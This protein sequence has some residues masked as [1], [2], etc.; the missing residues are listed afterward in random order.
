LIHAL[1]DR[2]RGIG[3]F[4]NKPAPGV[5]DVFLNTVRKDKTPVVI[6]LVSGIK[7]IG[8]I[9]SFDKYSVLLENNTENNILEQLIYKHSISTVVSCRPGSGAKPATLHIANALDQ[10]LANPTPIS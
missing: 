7:L 9:R 3:A 10:Q 8:K 5:Q 2:S 6:Y 1:P 4:D